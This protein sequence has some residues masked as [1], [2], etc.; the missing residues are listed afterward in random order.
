MN[1]MWKYWFGIVL[2]LFVA[3]LPFLG[4]P[5]SMKDIFYVLCGIALVAIFFMLSKDR[6]R[7]EK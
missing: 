3:L 7:G 1:K 4:F 6:V 5:R 2:S